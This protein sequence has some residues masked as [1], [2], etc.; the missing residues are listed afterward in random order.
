MPPTVSGG[1]LLS[2][3]MRLVSDRVKSVT[4]QATD[5]L[6]TTPA[7]QQALLEHKRRNDAVRLREF[8]T[9]RQMRNRAR[10]NE[11][12]W[13]G[14]AVAVGD[15]SSLKSSFFSS[16]VLLPLEDRAS[17]IQK[18]NEIEAQMSRQW[19]VPSSSL[20]AGSMDPFADSRQI[21]PLQHPK[22]STSKQPRLVGQMEG[23]QPLWVAPLFLDASA[24]VD[25]QRA[26]SSAPFPWVLDWS[27]FGVLDI[28]AARGLLLLFSGW[29]EQDVQLHFLGA[30]VLCE[31]LEVHTPASR[32]DVEPFWWTVRLAAL[33][34]MNLQDAFEQVARDFFET[35][36]LPAPGWKPPRCI[37][38]S[39]GLL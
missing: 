20:G 17:T 18:I 34:A 24:V 2:K 37:C 39:F 38:R 9:L 28:P 11:G 5:Q 33:R 16:S 19:E 32:C 4:D 25:L 3:L 6:V 10:A 8:D 23:A 29:A 12:G 13:T 1:G 7:D 26:L 22:P 14:E 15:Q 36:G 31:R 30:D 21:Q 35:Y 27:A